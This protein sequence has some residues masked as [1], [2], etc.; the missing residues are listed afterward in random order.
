MLTWSDKLQDT[1]FLVCVNGMF[2]GNPARNCSDAW[3]H[4]EIIIIFKF[5][6]RN[7]YF[8]YNVVMLRVNDCHFELTN[9][10]HWIELLTLHNSAFTCHFL[11]NNSFM[12]PSIKMACFFLVQGKFSPQGD[13]LMP[14]E[15][16]VCN[17]CLVENKILTY[18]LLHQQKNV[19][20]S[21]Y[22]SF[23]Y[24]VSFSTLQKVNQKGNN[25]MW[26]LC[27]WFWK[28]KFP[29]WKKSY[30]K[31]NVQNECLD[32]HAIKLM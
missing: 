9:A 3:S 28:M 20:A 7:S 23:P 4:L 24:T 6:F 8:F 21:A 2:M 11:L 29:K 1:F 14:Q 5:L 16:A 18:P 25:L 22:G 13:G 32:I 10:C 30:I 19:T 12:S 27:Q 31:Q 15:S 17:F 26:I